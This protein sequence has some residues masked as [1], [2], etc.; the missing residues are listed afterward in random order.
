MDNVEW[1]IC[2]EEGN[3]LV[4][5][6]SDRYCPVHSATLDREGVCPVDGLNWTVFS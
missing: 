5:L 2:D 6:T 1:I 3:D 4:V